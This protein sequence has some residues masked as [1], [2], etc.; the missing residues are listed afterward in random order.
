MANMDMGFC[1]D[2]VAFTN[3]LSTVQLRNTFSALRKAAGA[4]ALSQAFLPAI[5]LLVGEFTTGHA[6]RGRAPIGGKT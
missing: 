4:S 3:T 6:L 1:D 2:C 5:G